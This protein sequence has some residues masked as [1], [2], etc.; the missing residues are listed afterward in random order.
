MG[1]DQGLVAEAIPVGANDM[2]EERMKILNMLQEG[3]ITAAEASNLM[4]AIGADSDLRNISG[5]GSSPKYLV[6]KVVPREGSDGHSDVERVNIR[7][8]LAIL[9]AGV[10]LGAL[11]PI[12]AHDKVDDAMNKHGIH[13]DWKNLDDSAIDELIDSLAEFQVDAGGRDHEVT[14]RAE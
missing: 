6:V 2:N 9:R 5:S 11:I 13:F 1:T 4:D 8:P 10:K 7:I 14:I 3:K 12:S